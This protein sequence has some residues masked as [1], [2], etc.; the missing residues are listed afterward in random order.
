VIIAVIA[1][2]MVQASFVDVV[3]VVSMGN[4]RMV[5]VF[6]CF[7]IVDVTRMLGA[8]VI[9]RA[10]VGIL[11]ADLDPVVFD[12][13]ALLM[14]E[15]AVVQVINVIAVPNGHVPAS[16]AV[17]MGHGWT[18]LVQSP[19]VL[20]SLTPTSSILQQSSHTHIG[21]LPGAAA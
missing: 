1:V 15:P 9:R 18:P 6:R 16:A 17:C 11:F 7:P 10:P 20:L 12:E 14:L 3:D 21:A 4:R 13:V 8:P 5:T 19:G 2:V